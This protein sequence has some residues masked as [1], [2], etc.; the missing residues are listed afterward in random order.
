MAAL[1]HF[2]SQL[3]ESEALH[4]S[5][6]LAFRGVIDALLQAIKEVEQVLVDA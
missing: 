1:S 3:E 5:F 2:I 4:L 6:L